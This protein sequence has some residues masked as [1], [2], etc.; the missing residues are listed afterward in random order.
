M[1]DDQ[2][3]SLYFTVYVN[4]SSF[5]L[6]R[7]SLTGTRMSSVLVVNP[8]PFHSQGTPNFL[9]G[10]PS[11]N[12]IF[13]IFTRNEQDFFVGGIDL[14]TSSLTLSNEFTYED[15]QEPSAPVSMVDSD[16]VKI[17]CCLGVIRFN[18]PSSEP[19][20]LVFEI[21]F[22]SRRGAACVLQ[23]GQNYY[24]WR[25]LLPLFRVLV[26][27]D[28]FRIVLVVLSPRYPLRFFQRLG[29]SAQIKHRSMSQ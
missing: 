3:E 28:S 11:T 6:N 9:L 24:G 12:A 26:S 14:Q 13:S 25:E 21:D 16:G 8:V 19:A 5:Y 22:Q 1:F 15:H 2:G 7:M 4:G 20:F 27:H 23:V 29:L 17:G 18:S 10:T